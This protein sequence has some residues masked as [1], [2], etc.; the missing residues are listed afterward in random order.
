MYV[1]FV[2]KCDCRTQDK[3]EVATLYHA[4]ER[5]EHV[6]SVGANVNGASA[7]VEESAQSMH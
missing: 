2:F 7:D 4:S 5:W 1:A 6:E 3:N